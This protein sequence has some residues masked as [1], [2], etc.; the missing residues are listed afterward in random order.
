MNHK[1]I[2]NPQ[3][4]YKN[5]NYSNILGYHNIKK[6]DLHISYKKKI[7]SRLPRPYYQSQKKYY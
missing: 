1:Q 4:H 5:I 7:K 2:W 6:K 3:N